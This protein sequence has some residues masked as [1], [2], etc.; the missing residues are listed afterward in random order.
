RRRRA[1]DCGDQPRLPA[2]GRDYRR[3]R[4]CR[5]QRRAPLYE[6]RGRT[7]RGARFRCRWGTACAVIELLLAAIV[8]SDTFGGSRPF[9]AGRVLLVAQ[10]VLNPS[11]EQSKPGE[12]AKPN[13]KDE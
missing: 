6:S 8:A 4:G 10:T 9:D 11:N 13:I 3:R 5:C 7:E 1:G 2:R 12:P